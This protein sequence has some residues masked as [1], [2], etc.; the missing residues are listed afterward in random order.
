MNQR[1]QL[2]ATVGEHY[3]PACNCRNDLH[4]HGYRRCCISVLPDCRGAVGS[5]DTRRSTSGSV[6]HVR[7]NSGVFVDPVVAFH[8]SGNHFGRRFMAGLGYVDWMDCAGRASR[9]DLLE[10]DNT[11]QIRAAVMGSN[12][13]CNGWPGSICIGVRTSVASS[14]KAPR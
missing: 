13:Q 2:T 7:P 11:I 9:G 14:L 12:H 3:E 8:G 10:L 4:T 5:L 1:A 6:V